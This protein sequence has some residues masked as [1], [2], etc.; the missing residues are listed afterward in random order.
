MGVAFRTYG[1]ET[2]YTGF[3]W[4]NLKERDHLEYT[5][6]EGKTTFKWIFKKW[7]LELCTGSIWL[8]IGTRCGHL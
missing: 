2:V 6:I 8:R 4:R 1:V 5:G 3:W 7:D